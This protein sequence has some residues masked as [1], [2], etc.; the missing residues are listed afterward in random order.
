MIDLQRKGDICIVNNLAIGGFLYG[1]LG[2]RYL[3]LDGDGGSFDI[4]GLQDIG[5]RISKKTYRMHRFL[6][7]RRS[8]V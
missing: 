3:I 1:A 4:G 8:C 6:C 7:K 5:R 2:V